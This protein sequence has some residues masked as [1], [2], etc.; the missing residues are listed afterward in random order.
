MIEFITD[1]ER[2]DVCWFEIKTGE[3]SILMRDREK[4]LKK[5]RA[6]RQLEEVRLYRIERSATGMKK[7]RISPFF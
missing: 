2:Y 1:M 3:K 7:S 5:S 4:F 6:L